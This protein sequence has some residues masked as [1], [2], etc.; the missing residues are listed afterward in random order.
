MVPPGDLPLAAGEQ[1]TEGFLNLDQ[2]LSAW[3]GTLAE[4]LLLR[5]HPAAGGGRDEGGLE[6][7]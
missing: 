5:S 6:H 1:E 7:L 3:A 2:K 4:V